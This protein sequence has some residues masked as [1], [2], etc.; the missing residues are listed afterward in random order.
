MSKI[1]GSI[2]DTQ[3][4]FGVFTRMSVLGHNAGMFVYQELEALNRF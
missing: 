4:P 3:S 2:I 1:E